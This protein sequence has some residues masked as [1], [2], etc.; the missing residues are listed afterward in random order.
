MRNRYHGTELVLV[1][2]VFCLASILAAAPEVSDGGRIVEDFDNGWSFVRGD[3]TAAQTVE[4]DD[5]GWKELDLPH[6]WSIEGPLSKDNPTGSSGGYFPLGIGWYR[7]HFLVDSVA[8]DRNV[9]IEFDGIYKDSEV[10]INGHSVGKRWYGYVA[11]RYDLT[12]WIRWGEEN[13]IAVRVDN[14]KQTCRWYS[15][16]GIYRHVKL[17]LTNKL[18]IDQWGVCVTTPEISESRAKVNVSAIV[19]NRDTQSNL[20]TVRMKI[21]DSDY[22][23]VVSVGSSIVIPGGGEHEFC[24][25]MIVA[26]PRLWSVANPSIYYV[27]TSVWKS[28]RMVDEIFTP[29]GIRSV[30]WDSAKGLF[31]NDQPT[32]L[33]GVCIHHDLGCLGSAFNKR[34]MQR[35]LE[36]L[37][38]MGCNAIRIS[39]NPPASGLLDLCDEMGFLVIDEA[40]DKWG[41]KNHSTFSETWREDLEAMVLR[42]RNHPSIILWSVGNEVRQQGSQE[43]RRILKELV[44]YVHEKEPTRKVTYGA[45][46]SYGPNFVKMVDVA[47]FNY[48][49]QWF[50][51]YRKA[52]PDQLIMSTESF[53]YYRGKGDTV[54]AFEPM[55][56]WLEVPEND[57]VVG[58]FVWTGIDYL[59]EAIAGWPLHGW[60]CSLIDTCGFQRPVSYFHQSQW[61]DEPMVHIAVLDESLDVEKVAKEHWDWPKMVSHWTLPKLEG[62]NVKVV[63]FS[64]CPNVELKV[65][66]KSYGTKKLADFEDRMIT[67]D[68]PYKAGNIEA[69]GVDGDK[70]LCSHKLLTA[71]KPARI[72]LECD[73]SVISAD[74]D[75]VSHVTVHVVDKDSVIVP[76]SDASFKFELTGPGTIAGVDN[77]DLWSTEPYKGTKRKAYHGRCLVIVRS[78]TKAG[79]IEL[80]ASAEGMAKQKVTLKTEKDE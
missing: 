69:V 65:N 44:D 22:Y 59:G 52:N 33:K 56:P 20:C 55:N 16:S 1:I 5:S 30:R 45:Y 60:N 62:K 23:P 32:V 13:V 38:A 79:K 53:V 36:V 19:R 74:G 77:G 3:V 24:E 9:Y 27:L 4:F 26:S 76:D 2:F 71:G 78:Q 58:S 29:F 43:G 37:K 39:H 63:T 68:V 35:R 73:R 70:K 6:D 42:D 51:K 25:D 40:F 75:D 48:Q 28:G 8:K 41:G 17:I 31:V 54:K 7:K 67:W 72:V 47:G 18:Q 64:N 14:S 49:E 11:F 61:S 57:Y 15:G 34:A 46:P 66:G 10:W 21:L 12:D 80:T 50:E